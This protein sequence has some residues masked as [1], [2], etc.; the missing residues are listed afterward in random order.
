MRKQA[1]ERAE[2]PPLAVHD[3]LVNS[4]TLCKAD[5]LLSH[6]GTFMTKQAVERPETHRLIRSKRAQQAN[7]EMRR[8]SLSGYLTNGVRIDIII[9]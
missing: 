3:T 2:S 4:L 7:R 9:V 6:V 5:T 8:R 1:G